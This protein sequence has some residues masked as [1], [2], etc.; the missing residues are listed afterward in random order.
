VFSDWDINAKCQV[1]GC[2]SPQTKS[3]GRQAKKITDER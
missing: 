2:N 1:I 3:N